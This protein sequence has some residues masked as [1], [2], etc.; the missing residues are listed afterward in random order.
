MKRT[1]LLPIALLLTTFSLC[2]QQSSEAKQTAFST[3]QA[4]AKVS[5]DD[6]RQFGADNCFTSSEIDDALFC[7]IYGRSFK[8]NCTTPRSEL[9]YLKL[10]HYNLDGEILLGEMICNKAISD[11]LIAIFKTL[12]KAHYPI[13]RMVLIDAYDANDD[14]S[15][16]ANNSS[17]FNFRFIAGTTKLSSHSRG[18]AVDINPLYNPYVKVRGDR[19]I[20]EPEASRKYIDRAQDFPC[21]IDQND[22]CYKQ[23]LKYGFEWGGDWKSLK[24][25]QH[26]EKIK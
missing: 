11:D 2:A 13:E 17:A 15:M 9:C 20:V 1:V 16:L 24:D 22:L 5:S 25:Y 4:G 19:V 14:R 10:L 26:F 6:I 12:Y 8:E 21:K 23:F 18:M 3:W 7:R